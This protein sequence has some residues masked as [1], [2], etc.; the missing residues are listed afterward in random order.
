MEECLHYHG[1]HNG[2]AFLPVFWY[3]ENN[4]WLMA[5]IKMLFSAFLG[6]CF[7]RFLEF[8]QMSSHIHVQDDLYLISASSEKTTNCKLWG[9]VTNMVGTQRYSTGNICVRA[10]PTL[11]RGGELAE[12]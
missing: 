4:T 6:S 7:Q 8:A 5:V 3:L 12:V 1:L 11:T 2:F 10:E 9:V